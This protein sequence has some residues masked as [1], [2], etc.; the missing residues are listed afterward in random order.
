LAVDYAALGGPDAS[1]YPEQVR[2]TLVI[3]GTLFIGRALVRRLLA[4]GDQVTI[5]HR[6]SR[7]P[8]EGETEEIRC[9]R[10]DTRAI[11]QAIGGRFD[12][13]FDNVYDWER[14]TTAEQ[15]AAAARACGPNLERYIF[16][17]STAAYGQGL[18]HDEDDALSP[19]DSSDDYCRNKAETERML[20]ALHRES[21]FPAVTLRPPYIYGAENP[22]ERE[23][24]F[25]ERLAAGRPIIVPD[26]GSRLMQFCYR[27]DLVEAALRAS[28]R[29]AAVGR[30][31]NIANPAAITQLNLI[32]ALGEAAGRQPEVVA[33]PRAKLLE[34]GGGVFEPPYYF[35][36]YFDMPPIS[37]RIDRARKEL[38]FE[39]TPF[40]QGL[41]ETFEWFR[42]LDRVEP[43]FSFDEQV[44]GR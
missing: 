30:A 23:Q 12:V 34:L 33:V 43:D 38:E 10:N 37:E 16:M 7:N 3:G 29:E 2:R 25:F 17:S 9:D 15:V 4:R 26:D 20:F 18:D 31:Y 40:E 39:P 11:A 22:F 8:F 27:D 35:G 5:L 28:E 32:R 36:Q 6:G 21:G 13:V 14:G 24:F 1:S 41:Q 19:A 42:G 44:L